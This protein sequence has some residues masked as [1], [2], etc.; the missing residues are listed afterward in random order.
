LGV[1]WL[2]RQAGMADPSSALIYGLSVPGTIGVAAV[3]WHVFEKPL[4]DLKRH[5]PYHRPVRTERHVAQ[6]ASRAP[7]PRS[8]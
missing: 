7:S 5:L 6:A 4:N 3:S 8:P 2:L 1:F